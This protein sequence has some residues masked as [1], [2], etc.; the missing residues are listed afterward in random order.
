MARGHLLLVTGPPG[1]GKSTLCSHVAHALAS[2]GIAVSGFVTSERRGSSSQRIGFDVVAL[3]SLSLKSQPLARTPA[4]ADDPS[5]L[6]TKGVGKYSLCEQPF[7]SVALPV[8]NSVQ[9]K[10]SS[11]VVIDEVGKLELLADGFESALRNAID[12]C[13]SSHCSMLLS[14]PQARSGKPEPDIVSDL[15]RR[16]YLHTI[17]K[18]CRDGKKQEIISSLYIAATAS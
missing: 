8:L 7:L 11:V 18:S 14:V 16:G 12:A 4:T 15:K 10:A 13:E 5:M 2:E 17:D 9:Q 1:S 3:G 6:S